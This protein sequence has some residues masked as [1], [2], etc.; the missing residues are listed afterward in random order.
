MKFDPQIS[1]SRSRYV[2]AQFLV[3][4]LVALFI[5]RAIANVG[6][7]AVFVPSLLLWVHLYTIGLLNEGR[8]YAARLEAL[9]LLLVLPLGVLV[10][11]DSL[12]ALSPEFLG[13][14]ALYIGGS[15]VWLT[16]KA[17]T[18]VKYSTA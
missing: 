7:S 13:C 12:Q 6:A 14:L 11:N 16:T 1:R 18:P 2:L 15:L 8:P 3:A 10:L 9:R 4:I 5:S 17:N